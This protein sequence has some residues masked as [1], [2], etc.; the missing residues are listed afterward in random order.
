M[1]VKI[2]QYNCF[3]RKKVKE[4]NVENVTFGPENAQGKK[5]KTCRNF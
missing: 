3:S 1:F 4:L 5:M 2:G